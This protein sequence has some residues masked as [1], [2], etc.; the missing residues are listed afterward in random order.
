MKLILMLLGTC[1]ILAA[2]DPVR[3]A[4]IQVAPRPQQDADSTSQVAAFAVAE[5]VAHSHGLA[6]LG[7]NDRGPEDW[8][9]CFGERSLFLCWKVK[10]REVQFRIREWGFHLSPV[11]EGIRDDLIAALRAKFGSARVRECRWRGNGCAPLSIPEGG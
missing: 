11:A 10:G 8:T 5:R 6:Q 2:C 7:P 9:S 4:A 3:S 1:C